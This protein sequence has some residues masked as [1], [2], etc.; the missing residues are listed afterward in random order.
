MAPR[1]AHWKQDY[2]TLAHVLRIRYTR[3]YGEQAQCP[4]ELLPGEGQ[5]ARWQK[6]LASLQLWLRCNMTIDIPKVGS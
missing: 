4:D 5:K 1:E 3:V 6:R 2:E